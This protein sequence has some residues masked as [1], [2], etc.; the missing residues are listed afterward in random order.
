MKPIAKKSMR[1]AALLVSIGLFCGFCL[2]F[3]FFGKGLQI[4]IPS[5]LFCIFFFVLCALNRIP[6]TAKRTWLK[7]LILV[8]L[9]V[10]AVLLL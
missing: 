5:I 6:F 2:F 3:L 7:A 8:V 9:I 10:I 4:L 1:I